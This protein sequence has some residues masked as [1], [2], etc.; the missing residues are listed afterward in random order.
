MM[1]VRGETKPGRKF[2]T[3]DDLANRPDVLPVSASAGSARR[4]DE[5][6][7]ES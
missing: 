5:C 4:S 7:D 2:P 3:I 1:E 6:A